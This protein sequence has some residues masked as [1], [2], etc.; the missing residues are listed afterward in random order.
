MGN[1]AKNSGVATDPRYYLT[2]VSDGDDARAEQILHRLLDKGRYVFA[3]NAPHLNKL[4]AGDRLCFY[5]SGLGVAAEVEILSHPRRTEVPFSRRGREFPYEV[6]VARAR[7][8][9]N[10]PV[11]IDAELRSR[12]DAFRDRYRETNWALFVRTMTWLTAHDF[13]LLAGGSQQTR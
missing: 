12:L 9:F 6:E 7:F 5:V 13:S 11:K 10:R 4:K 8:F 1:A 2:S 3:E